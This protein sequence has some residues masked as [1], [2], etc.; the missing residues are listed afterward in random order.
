MV[1]VDE[2]DS[3]ETQGPLWNVLRTLERLRVLRATR[4]GWQIEC[5]EGFGFIEPMLG[6]VGEIAEYMPCVDSYLG[7]H[8]HEVVE[9]SHG[10]TLA[11]F[12]DEHFDCP[13]FPVERWERAV[14]SPDMDML[15]LRTCD[16]LG[17]DSRVQVRPGGIAIDQHSLY[18]IG[19][20][21]PLESYE[22]PVVL[23]FHPDGV[24]TE[25]ALL[26]CAAVLDGPFIFLTATPKPAFKRVGPV[27]SGRPVLVSSLADCLDMSEESVLSATD[28]WRASLDCFRKKVVPSP[29]P[30]LAFF[31]TPSGATWERVSIRFTDHHTVLVDAAGT[32]GK[33]HYTEMGMSNRRESMP[34]KQWKFLEMIAENHG[35]ID[36]QMGDSRKNKSWKHELSV[37]LRRFFHISDDPF[38]YDQGTGCWQARFRV[39][40]V[41]ST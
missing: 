1:L 39:F 30:A 12:A 34:S 3:S 11:V 5:G 40:P 26:V 38:I 15:A 31:E 8:Y 27:V 9:F 21:R 22:F 13:S 2:P 6:P 36:F 37:N 17:L 4:R 18:E 29:G 10:T 32:R 41:G 14:L 7:L 23:S 33:F 24:T 20:Y 25:E 16:A 28:R 35:T 19:C